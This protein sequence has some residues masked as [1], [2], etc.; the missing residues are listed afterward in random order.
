MKRAISVAFCLLILLGTVSCGKEELQ[1]DKYIGEGLLV[2]FKV[3][4]DCN[5]EFYNDI[6]VLGH[7]D[8]DKEKQFE[9]DGI[10]W[11]P[12]VSEKYKTYDDLLSAMRSVYTEDCVQAILK[13]YDFYAD[14]DGVL[15][16]NTAFADKVESGKK[17]VRTDDWTPEVE[18]KGEAY[19]Q[20]EYKF[21]AGKS[22]EIDEFRFDKTTNGY[23]LTELQRVD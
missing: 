11:A 14:V 9:K 4:V 19:Y 23:R 6:F 3:M 22:D 7:L 20:V 8:V 21:Y 18:E 12:V 13:K 17:W 5:Q 15:C 10:T 16:F 2:T 1:S